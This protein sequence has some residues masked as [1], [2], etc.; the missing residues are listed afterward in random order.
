MP[1]HADGVN[2]V[3]FADHTLPPVK[4]GERVIELMSG[5]HFDNLLQDTP[6]ELRP[7]SVI[8][9]KGFKTCPKVDKL[10]RF[11]ELAETRLPSR[12]R[13]LIATYDLDAN[14][15]R[16]WFKFTPEMDLAARFNVKEC[17]TIVFVPRGKNCNGMTEWCTKKTEDPHIQLVGC[18][19]FVDKCAPHVKRWD[20]KT[21]LLQWIDSLVVEEGEPEIS[22]VLGSYKDQGRWILNRDETTTDNELRNYHLVEAFPAFTNLGFLAMPIPQSINEWFLD[23]WNRKKTERTVESWHASSTQMSFHEEAT[24]FVSLD[25][26]GRLRDKY[27]NEVIKPIVEKWSG[28]SNLELTSFYGIREY[29]SQ[30]LRGHIDR[31]DTHVLSVTF[32]LGKLNASNLNQILPNEVAAKMPSWPLEVV[33]FDGQIYRHDHPA[34]TMI[35]YESSKLVH[36]RPYHNAGPPHLGAFCHFRPVNM[37]KLE[38][39]KWEEIADA[40]RANQ[41]KNSL[42]SQ[43]RSTQSVE[44]KNPVFSKKNYAENT[45]FRRSDGKKMSGGEDDDEQM[46]DE[47][48]KSFLITFKN[49][50]TEPLDIHWVDSSKQLHLQGTVS[51]GSSFEVVTYLGH[52]FVWT[53]TGTRKRMPKGMFEVE[54][55]SHVY[56]YG[57][58]DV[59][60]EES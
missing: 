49:Q 39:E 23:F 56:R 20:K 19:N 15:K 45:G 17:G 58:S 40:A 48:N 11:T 29:K 9:F 10:L 59:L 12:E 28:I 31:I 33:A 13:L 34:G 32:C 3:D 25:V 47:E 14:L 6:D 54:A 52:K 57:A 46:D 41:E 8:L 37:D 53:E 44:P 50:Y 60:K 22:P 27:A 1:K 5:I 24:T 4:I 36:G 55:G 26:E 51:P 2:V 16:A 35:L 42:H 38:A 7:P 43:Y 18:E 21:Q 30:W